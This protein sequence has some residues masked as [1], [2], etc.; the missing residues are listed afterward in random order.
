MATD[1]ELQ[2]LRATP[3]NMGACL[4]VCGGVATCAM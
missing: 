4:E 1:K 3:R 2:L